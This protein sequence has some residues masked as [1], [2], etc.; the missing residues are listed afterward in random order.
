V[1]GFTLI[2]L[3]LVIAIIAILAAMLLPALAN[4]KERAKRIQCL[5]NLRQIGVA[6]N[7][8]APDFMDKVPPGQGSGASA[9]PPYVQD[10]LAP[11]VVTALNS[12]MK[13]TTNGSSV[14]TCPE[15][16]AGLPQY[17]LTGT[18]AQVYIGYSY[19]GGMKSWANLPATPVFGAPTPLA[20]SP[21]KLSTSKPSWVLGADAILKINGQWS[22]AVA[23]KPGNTAYEFEYGNVPPHVT[24][25]GRAA[26]ANEVMADASAQWYSA[27]LGKT[28]NMWGFNGYAGAI[29][30]VTIYWHQDSTD[31]TASQVALLNSLRLQ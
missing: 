17:D 21:I 14:W 27:Y 6:A 19:M 12:Y 16:A 18:P 4:A 13:I 31:F 23:S 11:N 15:R 30:Q 1:T 25:G 10:A 9:G 8:Y 24:G 3:L 22:S 28:G 26:G 7:V 29:G 2:E 5:G 20:Y